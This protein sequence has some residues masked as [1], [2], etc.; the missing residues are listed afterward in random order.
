MDIYNVST[1]RNIEE[2]IPVTTPGMTTDLFETAFLIKKTAAIRLLMS[3][4][5]MN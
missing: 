2:A 5:A 1:M 4:S 3:Q